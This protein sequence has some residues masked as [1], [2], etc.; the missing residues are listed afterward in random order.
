MTRAILDDHLLRDLLADDESD[1]LAALLV[2][3]QPATTNLFLFRLSRSVV[4]ARGGALTGGWTDERR[5]ALGAALLGSSEEVEV[6]PIRVL[7]FRMAEI[8]ADHGV[9]TLGAEAIAAAE[10]LGA[11]LCVWDGD[12]GPRIRAGM[13][14]LDLDY[15]TIVR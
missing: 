11:P 3:Y 12:D 14:R 15:R 9:S 2:G 8:A 10:H 6:L 7:S 5:R 1:D 4:A 13:S